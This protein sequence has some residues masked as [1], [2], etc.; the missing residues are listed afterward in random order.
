MRTSRFAIFATVLLHVT[1]ALAVTAAA[2]DQHSGTWKMNPA[3]LFLI[4]GWL[5][6]KQTA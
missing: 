5:Q 4:G 3:A 2:A 1:L 6:A